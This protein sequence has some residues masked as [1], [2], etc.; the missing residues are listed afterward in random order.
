MLNATETTPLLNVFLVE[1][2]PTQAAAIINALLNNPS[3]GGAIAVKH[4]LTYREA[5]NTFKT[6]G[7]IYDLVILDV[8][9][10]D[11]NG[12]DL[13]SQFRD[14]IEPGKAR[15]RRSGTGGLEPGLKIMVLSEDRLG[16]LRKRAFEAGADY[17]VSK[18][19]TGETTLIMYVQALLLQKRR[20][21]EV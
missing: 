16:N 12:L 18:G 4:A 11:G 10:P 13:C 17:C 3:V 7:S 14:I 2:S 20:N 5:L 8:H 9:L 6:T 15:I 19:G 1:D 21:T